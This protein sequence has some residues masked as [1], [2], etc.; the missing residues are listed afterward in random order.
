MPLSLPIGLICMLLPNS[1]LK[2]SFIS[3]N[4]S[5]TVVEPAINI[6]FELIFSSIA[7][8]L[9]AEIRVVDSKRAFIERN[10]IVDTNSLIVS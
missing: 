2:S 3:T 1:W 5:V 7:Y 4:N 10:S 8:A 9:C 6:G